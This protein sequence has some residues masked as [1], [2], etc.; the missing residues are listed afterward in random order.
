MNSRQLQYITKVAET[1]SISKAAEELRISQPSLSQMIKSVERTLGTPIFDRSRV[2]ATLTY[3]GEKYVEAA[4]KILRIEKQM[5]SEMTEIASEHSGKIR[6]GISMHRAIAF[7]PEI[8][9][10]FKQE[11]PHVEVEIHELG[12][13]TLENHAYLQHV[14]LAFATSSQANPDMVY[15]PITVEKIFLVAGKNTNIARRIESGKKISIKEARIEEFVVLKKGHAIRSIQD[16]LFEDF[17]LYPSVYCETDSIELAKKMA[18]YCDKVALYPEIITTSLQM[19]YDGS[20]YEIERPRSYKT[21]CLCY[22]KDIQIKKY[23]Q[24]FIDIAMAYLK[25]ENT[26]D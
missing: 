11:H 22:H 9:M 8:L 6:L 19:M 24:R 7:L 14:D 4:E 10:Q 16:E 15:L 1:G 26:E 23:M 5:M 18:L 13:S 21:F 17:K 3:A 25:K 20:Y 2:P 12:S